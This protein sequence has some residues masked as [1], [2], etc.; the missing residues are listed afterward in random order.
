MVGFMLILPSFPL[1]IPTVFNLQLVSFEP[2][3]YFTC[4]LEKTYSLFYDS[5]V[6]AYPEPL[7]CKLHSLIKILRYPSFLQPFISHDRLSP[8]LNPTTFSLPTL[9]LL[10]SV[11]QRYSKMYR[12]KRYRYT[13]FEKKIG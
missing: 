8:L 13:I 9:I 1:I 12:L 2:F 5:P 11:G 7:S 10:T 6:F 3:N 4:G